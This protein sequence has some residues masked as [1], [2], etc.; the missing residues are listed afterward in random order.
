MHKTNTADKITS[1]DCSAECQDS[2]LA[3]FMLEGSFF[4]C[5]I[6]NSKIYIYLHV[7]EY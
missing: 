2:M 1:S 7:V 5:T 6:Q 4:T 3:R